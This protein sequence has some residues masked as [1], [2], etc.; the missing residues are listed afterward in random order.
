MQEGR[1]CGDPGLL[2]CVGK[3]LSEAAGHTAAGMRDD[4]GVLKK[5]VSPWRVCWRMAPRPLGKTEPQEL[6]C[7]SC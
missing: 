7:L 1:I 5:P 2:H 4:P 3:T 6:D